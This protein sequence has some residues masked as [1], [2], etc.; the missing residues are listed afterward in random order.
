M[1]TSEVIDVPDGKGKTKAIGINLK[2]K[3][4]FLDVQTGVTVR[5]A[6]RIYSCIRDKWLL[7]CLRSSFEKQQWLEA[8]AEERRLVAQDKSDG[9]A[10]PTAA[11]QLAKVAARS[12]RRPPRK[13]RGEDFNAE[14]NEKASLQ[15]IRDLLF[16]F[17]GNKNYKLDSAYMG[18]ML[19]LNSHNSHNSHSLGRKVGTWFTFG[20][21]RKTRHQHRDVS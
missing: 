13:P 5:H 3:E 11:K 20:V 21:N 10:F 12:Q 2:L 4:I 19:Q 14:T 1:D 8:F 6:L 9:L 7:C 17:L 16:L 15:T 18:S